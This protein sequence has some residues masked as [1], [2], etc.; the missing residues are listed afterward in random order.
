[1]SCKTRL[2]RK[3]ISRVKC[4]LLKIC[5]I[6]HPELPTV[7]VV[8]KGAAKGSFFMLAIQKES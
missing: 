4:R 6:K 1:M 2:L 8:N 5:Q 3:T 7:A